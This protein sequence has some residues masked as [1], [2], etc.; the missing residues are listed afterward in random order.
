MNVPSINAPI[1]R[2]SAPN[3]AHGGVW[4]DAQRFVRVVFLQIDAQH[5]RAAHVVQINA[6]VF[7]AETGTLVPAKSPAKG[8]Y[9]V[10]VEVGPQYESQR[11]A[12]IE[13]MEK[14][15]DMV[16]QESRYFPPLLAMWMKNISGTGLGELKEFNRMEML[17]LGLTEPEN[18]EEAQMLQQ[19]QQEVDPQEE[20]NDAIAVQQKAEA[21]SLVAS[22]KNKDADT[23]KKAAET[24]Q[25][26][27]ETAETLQS[28]RGTDGVAH[29]TYN[30]QTGGLDATAA[31]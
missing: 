22:A 4:I 17:K 3:F 18:E 20:L 27:V 14:V 28:M 19:L 9:K 1:A 12:T 2:R 26:Q 24:K 25:I 21:I 5:R 31:S 29:L 30:P 7:D 13:T 6:A 15:M 11:E 8:R 10:D 16:G 23:A